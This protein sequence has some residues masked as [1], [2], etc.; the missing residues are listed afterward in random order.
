MQ[1]KMAEYKKDLNTSSGMWGLWDYETYKEIDE[2]DRWEPLFCED[3][4]IIKQIENNTFVPVNI[5]EDGCRAFTLKI[6]MELS[7]R[8]EKYYC[9]K[10]EQYLF[11]SNGKMILSG[12]DYIDKDV[13]DDEAIIIDLPKG[14]YTA[15]IYLI[16][17]DEE[18]G[19]YLEDGSISPNALSDFVIVL[20]S[21]AN[22]NKSYRQ[23]INTFSE[24]D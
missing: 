5:Y 4:D 2:Y 19:A 18:P 21:N 24:D 17:W 14:F 3:E 6:D 11:C 12:I 20:K 23:R 7:E 10:S 8:E 22:E 15:V 13:S 1:F 16:A 9:V